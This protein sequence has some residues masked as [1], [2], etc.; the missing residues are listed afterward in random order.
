MQA[1]QIHSDGKLSAYI[2][3]PLST[4]HLKLCSRECVR[5]NTFFLRRF[6]ICICV[7][8]TDNEDDASVP[9]SS[10]EGHP[11]PMNTKAATT[12][13]AVDKLTTSG[14]FFSENIKKNYILLFLS[15][16]KYQSTR[17]P[18]SCYCVIKTVTWL[19][20]GN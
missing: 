19:Y 11:M 7:F 16:E 12:I 9:M 13:Q 14:T 5:N 2:K 10:G 1:V 6:C 20:L 17:I 3:V 18:N 4:K 8:G 15:T